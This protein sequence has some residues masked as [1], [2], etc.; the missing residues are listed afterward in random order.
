MKYEAINTYLIVKKETRLITAGGI[1]V[2]AA[3]ESAVTD[4]DVVATTD[5]TKALQ[6]KTIY[7][8]RSHVQEL[9]TEGDTKYGA[10]RI[11]NVI[12]IKK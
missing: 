4:F 2:A 7:C 12:A 3:V 10:V 11:D 5:L 8:A 9:G 6:D 1:H